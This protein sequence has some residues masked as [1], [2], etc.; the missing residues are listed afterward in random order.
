MKL[1][2]PI[3]AERRGGSYWLVG[4]ELIPE[5]DA[6]YLAKRLKESKSAK[7]AKDSEE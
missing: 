5:S 2:Y 4:D 7:P 6:E 3:P 1:K